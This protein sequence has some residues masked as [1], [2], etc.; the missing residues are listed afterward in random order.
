MKYRR[1]RPEELEALRDEFVQFLAANSITAD[2]WQKLKNTKTEGAEK[3]ID[4]FSDIV[5]EKVLSKTQYV[6]VRH[7]KLLQ[8][9]K[10]GD[11]KAEMIQIAI[12]HP[13]FDFRRM[14]GIESLAQGKMAL[15]EIDPEI[16]AGKKTY[17]D[18]R[19]EE[20]F[21]HLERGGIAV[22]EGMWELMS[23]FIGQSK[24]SEE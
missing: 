20:V 21:L 14:E 3:L 10:F 7:A 11:E 16:H 12:K 8:I 24:T 13:D 1:L 19:N 2:D 17:S 4:V 5:W 9:M 6:E 22:D 15:S 23:T 18:T